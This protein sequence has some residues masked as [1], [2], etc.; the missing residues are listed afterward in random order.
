MRGFNLFKFQVEIVMPKTKSAKKVMKKFKDK[1]G[2]D[3]ESIYYATANKQGRDEKSFKKECIL[4]QDVFI[5]HDGQ[6]ITI[7]EGTVL[8]EFAMGTGAIAM[9]PAALGDGKAAKGGAV[10]M[11]KPEKSKVGGKKDKKK[12][13]VNESASNARKS[14]EDLKKDFLEWAGGFKPKDMDQIRAY[15]ATSS[16]INNKRFVVHVLGKWM[17]EEEIDEASNSQISPLQQD[18]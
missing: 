3:G 16:P 17:E 12:K 13:K 14:A 18:H 15:F 11:D 4:R 1:Y 2:K 6:M 10:A 7:P 5:E 8:K 9:V